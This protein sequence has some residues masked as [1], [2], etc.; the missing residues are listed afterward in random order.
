MDAQ[1]RR[2]RM[3]HRDMRDAALAEERAL[4]LV[5]AVDELVD[6]HEGAGR[7]FLL[8]RAAGRERDEIG[9]AGALEHVDIGAVVDVGRRQPVA[10]VVAREEHHRQAGDLA[11]AQRRRRLAPRALDA[12]LAHVLQA[13]QIV[14]AGAADDAEHGLGHA[15]YP[16][17]AWRTELLPHCGG[18][19]SRLRR[20]QLRPS[21]QTF[22][23]VKYISPARR[24]GRSSPGSR[25]ACAPRDAARPPTS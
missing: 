6:Q 8:E 3:R 16:A 23:L 25:C 10:L 9:D 24:S 1:P 21:A 7:Q 2:H 20:V 12:L 15:A 4:A 11:D 17:H 18:R 14:D 13:R 19:G 22:F 5:G